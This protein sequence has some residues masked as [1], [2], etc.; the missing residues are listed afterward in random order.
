MIIDY[1]Q[2]ELNK[3][4]KLAREYAEQYPAIA[5]LLREQSTD[6]DV[7]RLLEGVAFLTSQ[8][9]MVIDEKLPEMVD[10]LTQL[11]FSQYSKPIPSTS[12]I[13]F[14]P[15]DNLGEALFISKGTELASIPI[16]EIKCQFRTTIPI[17]VEPVVISS[18]DFQDSVSGISQIEINCRLCGITLGNW[19]ASS[20]R[21]FINQ[22]WQ[23]ASNTFYLLQRYVSRITVEATGADKL[24]LSPDH[25]QPCAFDNEETLYPEPSN[26]HHPHRVLY[27][28]INQPYKFL[29]LRLTGLEKWQ[30]NTDELDFKI[31]FELKEVPKWVS[32]L[33]DF[34]LVLNAVPIINLFDHHAEPIF[35]NHKQPDYRIVPNNDFDENYSVYEVKKVTGYR[36]QERKR[37]EYDHLLNFNQE[38]SLN[39]KYT[40]HQRPSVTG[41]GR[42]THI[43]FY[44]DFDNELPVD[45]TISVEL[46]CSNGPL[47]R[48]LD[49][50][51]ITLPTDSSPENLTY[52]NL[53]PP[54]SFLIPVYDQSLIWNFQSLLALN[55]LQLLDKN[56][57]RH[58]FNLY[59][60]E[61]GENY[62]LN[63]SRIKGI[64]SIIVDKAR[65]LYYGEMIAGSHITL[66]CDPDC[67][68]CIG[69]MYLF[70]C[71][72][73]V[74][75]GLNA[76]INTFTL[77]HL[78][79]A[80]TKEVWKWL[81]R[82]NNPSLAS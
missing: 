42:T 64:E 31:T 38:L 27:E 43:S 18:I 52:T 30:K 35:L 15:K 59:I 56:H 51:D 1:Y 8:V 11:F 55:L 19:Q 41:P 69:D 17:T 16:N 26:I 73:D 46:V 32:N 13:Q 67:F 82:L 53:I 65:R 80:R 76:P 20:L 28:Y 10:D 4:R 12:V 33:D 49:K 77:L 25:L 62:Q 24:V 78:E 3:I 22:N 57:L 5:P 44:Y 58:V 2:N 54:S 60:Y 61:K 71:V 48:L 50:D 14:I 37:I 47:T 9:Q 68:R 34:Q 74:F 45:E 81:P 79:N 63:M 39:Y 66:I 70:G 29:F 40:Y 36:Q 72:M 75:F 21:F 7:E 6:P 23:E